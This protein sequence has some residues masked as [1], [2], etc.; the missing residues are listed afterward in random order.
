MKRGFL[1]L[2]CM[3]AL[4]LGTLVV[5]GGCMSCVYYYHLYAQLGRQSVAALSAAVAIDRI[6]DEFSTCH[7]VVRVADDGIIAR[8]VLDIALNRVDNRLVISRGMYNE[9]HDRWISRVSS[10]VLTSV[11]DFGVTSDGNGVSC[12]VTYCE[13]PVVFFIRCARLHHEDVG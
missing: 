6:R 7:T 5:A 1:L 2:D 4:F 10:T 13:K 3:L 11:R 12:R 9:P 8:G